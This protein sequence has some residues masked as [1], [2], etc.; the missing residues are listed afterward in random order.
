MVNHHENRQ[1]II[2]MTTIRRF[3]CGDE[4]QLWM[5]Y[6]EATHRC[7]SK[8]Y[9][10]DLIER[11]APTNMDMEAW[12]NRIRE[13]NPFVAVVNEAPVGF[14]ELDAD[15]YIDYFYCHPDWQRQGIGRMLLERVELTAREIGIVRLTADVS[16][17]AKEFFLI[18]GFQV[19]EARRN[20]IQGHIAPNFAME[21]LLTA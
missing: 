12:G 20:I 1:A 8:D 21:K 3:R 2:P 10:A 16:V 7:N 15:G 5:I 18:H 4:R 11:W 6:Y 14:A 19:V 9:H 13:K 17:T